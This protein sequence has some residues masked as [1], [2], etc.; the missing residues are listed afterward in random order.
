MKRKKFLSACSLLVLLPLVA[1]AQ[2]AG[3]IIIFNDG[4]PLDAGSVTQLATSPYYSPSLNAISSFTISGLSIYMNAASGSA[5]TDPGWTLYTFTAGDQV[6]LSGCSISLQSFTI[7]NTAGQVS[8][9]NSFA[10]YTWQIINA[11]NDNL[12]ANGV[13]VDLSQFQNP[14]NGVFSTYA[15]SSDLF[16][17]YTPVPEPSTFALG[18]LALGLIATVRLSKKV[19]CEQSR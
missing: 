18:S 9:F 13:M 11:P 10:P 19:L 17:T 15:T 14:Y 2:G 5:S 6:T 7:A 12:V 3:S 16:L 4:I 8:D 1:R